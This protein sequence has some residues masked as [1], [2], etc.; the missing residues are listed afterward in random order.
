MTS[1]HRPSFPEWTRRTRR[2]RIAIRSTWAAGA[3]LAAITLPFFIS[4]PLEWL[5]WG[6]TLAWLWEESGRL[7]EELRN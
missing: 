1:N 2:R 6:V 3:G 7:V 5:L 4:T